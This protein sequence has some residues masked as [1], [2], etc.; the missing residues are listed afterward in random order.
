MFI[1]IFLTLIAVVTA[2]LFLRTVAL[3]FVYAV[4]SNRDAFLTAL[5]V[6]LLLGAITSFLIYFAWCR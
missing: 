6:S 3:G 2:V 1:S 4:F 5:V